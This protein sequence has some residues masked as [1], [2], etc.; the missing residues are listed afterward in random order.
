MIAVPHH[1]HSEVLVRVFGARQCEINQRM[2]R[3][4]QH[5]VQQLHLFICSTIRCS[6][7]YS[8]SKQ[9][10]QQEQRDSKHKSVESKIRHMKAKEYYRNTLSRL[11][12]QCNDSVARKHV[13]I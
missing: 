10:A 2:R 13:S 1:T 5:A 7:S 3:S 6:N 4:S 11:A 12:V 9:R 8:A